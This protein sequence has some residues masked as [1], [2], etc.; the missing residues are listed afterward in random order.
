[1]GIVRTGIRIPRSAARCAIVGLCASLI[2]SAPPAMAQEGFRADP[3]LQQEEPNFFERIGRWFDN[4]FKG[5]GREVENFGYEAGIAAKT[6]VQGAREA[7]DAVARIPKARVVKG[8]EK[9]RN[10][11]NGAPDCVAAANT[12]CRAQGFESGKSVDMTTA[13]VCPAKVYMSGRNSGPECRS[14]T[15]VSSVLCQ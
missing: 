13:E 12:M 9:C 10:A 15:F 2:L 8:H 11:P 7:A 3:R 5:A 14:E 1:M 6:T 4:T